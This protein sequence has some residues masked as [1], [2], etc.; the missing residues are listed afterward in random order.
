MC[1]GVC[2]LVGF[3]RHVG[4]QV[5]NPAGVH[6]KTRKGCPDEMPGTAKGEGGSVG[7]Q[8]PLVEGHLGLLVVG[9]GELNGVRHVWGKD[10]QIHGIPRRAD[11]E[12]V[13]FGGT[14]L[15]RDG[16]I[17]GGPNRGFKCKFALVECFHPIVRVGN[18]GLGNI[19]VRNERL[20][21]GCCSGHLG[22]KFVPDRRLEA[23]IADHGGKVGRQPN[24][25]T[26]KHGLI[27]NG[28]PI[29][30]MVQY[31]RN[32]T[33][34]MVHDSCLTVTGDAS[35][36]ITPGYRRSD[37]QHPLLFGHSDR[38]KLGSVEDRAGIVFEGTVT[39]G[40][41]ERV[42]ALAI[43]A[44]CHNEVLEGFLGGG[45]AL[46]VSRVHD[47]LVSV[48]FLAVFDM[49]NVRIQHHGIHDIEVIR[50]RL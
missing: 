28:T 22:G 37:H 4:E 39:V 10:C 48:A 6:L 12:I 42:V 25:E 9:M 18:P 21:L 1:V 47:P 13:V 45:V 24:N 46:G 44:L 35:G 19:R 31:V 36:N 7:N 11:Y 32:V 33:D 49:K 23:L 17:G 26:A 20:A 29:R 3:G 41:N 34:G 30:Q 8:R 38:F 5:G 40:F 50:V 27:R 14:V 16:A 15:K 2:C 43:A